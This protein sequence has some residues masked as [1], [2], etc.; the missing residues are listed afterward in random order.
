M[1]KI[2][3]RIYKNSKIVK[4]KKQ[5]V[6]TNKQFI[7]IGTTIVQPFLCYKG[8]IKPAVKF[9]LLCGMMFNFAYK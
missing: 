1:N 5:K 3:S 8:K 9:I 2:L 7:H 4:D 6:K